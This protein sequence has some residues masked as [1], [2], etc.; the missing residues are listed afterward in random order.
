MPIS[1]EYEEPQALSEEEIQAFVKYYA[2]AASNAMKAGFDGVEIHGTSAGI[3]RIDI[4]L[5]AYQAPMATSSINSGKVR[6]LLFFYTCSADT[7]QTSATAAPT[8]TAARSKNA[9]VS[10]SK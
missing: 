1:S 10:V 3:F 6:S 4:V 2:N 9:R 7:H 5:N 8:P